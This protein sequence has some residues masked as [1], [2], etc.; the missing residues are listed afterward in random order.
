MVDF[1]N[2]IVPRMGPDKAFFPNVDLTVHLLRVPKKG[3]LGFDTS[4]TFD[5]CGIGLTHS[6][7]HDADGPLG[8]VAQS[9]TVRPR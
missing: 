3:W 8:S 6:I 5:G 4:V 1:A 9:L 2:G 7:L